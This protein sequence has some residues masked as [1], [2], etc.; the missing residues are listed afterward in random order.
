MEY[1][2]QSKRGTGWSLAGAASEIQKALEAAEEEAAGKTS[3][4]IVDECNELARQFY[5][6][7]GYHVCSCGCVASWTLA[8]MAYE[9]GDALADIEGEAE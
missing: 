2:G 1:D 4:Q 3:Q 5:A 8:V 7:E 6:A 9:A